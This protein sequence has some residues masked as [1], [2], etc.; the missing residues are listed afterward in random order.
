MEKQIV[1]MNEHDIQVLKGRLNLGKTLFYCAIA[2]AGFA[3]MLASLFSS[4][5][6][7]VVVGVLLAFV[8]WLIMW[9]MN[10]KISHD[11]ANGEKSIETKPIGGVQANLL[12]GS[13]KLGKFGNPRVS[14][15]VAGYIL[16]IGSLH[17]MVG[18]KTYD[19][20]KEQSE[21]EF[22]YAVASHELL[23]IFPVG[24]N[25]LDEYDPE[26]PHLIL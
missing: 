7:G 1:R 4:I 6:V 13:A 15:S 18:K 5:V 20:L 10:H 26:E 12:H 8:G 14:Q 19:L 25:V 17:Y 2:F 3:I 9:T 23:G 11:I 22:H 21:C 16:N 24:S